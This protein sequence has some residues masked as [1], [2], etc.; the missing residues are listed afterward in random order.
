MLEQNSQRLGVTG[1]STDPRGSGANSQRQSL[2]KR[3]SPHGSA[4]GLQATGGSMYNTNSTLGMT[5]NGMANTQR[6]L[7]SRDSS[8]RDFASPGPSPGPSPTGTQMR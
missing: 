8:G 6:D 1:G 4:K 3:N 7:N 2:D 5:G